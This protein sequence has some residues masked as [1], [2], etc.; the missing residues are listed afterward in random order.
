MKR[1]IKS[2]LAVALL[3]GAGFSLRADN[4]KLPVVELL[5]NTY[6]V[7]KAKKG[8]SLFGIARTY[9]WDDKTLQKLNP[10]AVSP[11]QKGMKIYYPAPDQRAQGAV[12]APV[13][14]ND[15]ELRHTVKRGETVYAISNMYGVPVDRIYALN[16]DSRNG[17]KAGRPFSCAR[18]VRLPRRRMARSST[19]SVRVTRFMVWP[20]S[21]ESRW[22]L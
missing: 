18:P 19:L 6:Y 15:T 17:I 5:G 1:Y 16:P 8:D 20:V 9:G 7:Y 4:V 3:A 22:P 10:S 12:A 14:A 2:F 13:S 11:L 21:M